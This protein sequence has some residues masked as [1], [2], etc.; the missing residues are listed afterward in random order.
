MM[1]AVAV[2]GL[3]WKTDVIV[4]V[5]LG[6][7]AAVNKIFQVSNDVGCLSTPDAVDVASA[8]PDKCYAFC[9]ANTPPA[10]G[11]I[12]VFVSDHIDDQ[13]LYFD[14]ACSQPDPGATVLDTYTCLFQSATTG[15]ISST[16]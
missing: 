4:V 2:L 14:A 16:R 15:I 6:D 7:T 9:V 1:V 3:E 11:N 10:Q 12:L 5:D 8:D 13:C